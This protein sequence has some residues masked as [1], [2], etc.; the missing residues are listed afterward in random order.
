MHLQIYRHITAALLATLPIIATIVPLISCRPT[1]Y[2]AFSF[3]RSELNTYKEEV[4][5][6]FQ[7]GL[8]KYLEVGYPY[9]EV[10]PISCEPKTRNFNDL[11]DLPTNDVLGNF[12]ATLIDSLT[13]VAVMG[14]KNQFYNLVELVRV[15]F[16]NKFE[17]DATVQVFETTIRILGSLISSHLYATDARK[18]CNLLD[19]G[20][21]GILLDLAK[22]IGERLL[23]VY[24]TESGLPV[25]RIN[26][27]A[28]FER[29]SRLQMNENNLAGM[30]T[31]MLEFG[32]LS[33][34][35]GDRKYME[36]T[37]FTFDRLWK[38]FRARTGL[39]PVSL[40][41]HDFTIYSFA[42]GVGAS[43]D[44]FYEYALKGAILFDDEE[45]MNI[46]EESY[47][48]LNANSKLDW[49]YG[50]V[51][52]MGVN[53][54]LPW[55]D[56]LSAFFPGLQVLA[57]DVDDS[58][59]KH[60]L[61]LKQWDYF[62]G[63]PERWEFE[64]P[65][66][67]IVNR[68]VRGGFRKE[69]KE[70]GSGGGGG[71]VVLPLPW[72]PLRPEF[73][74]STYYLYRATK[75]PFYL[76]IGYRILQDFKYRFKFSCGFAGI[77]NLLTDQRQDRMET[78]VLSETLKYLYL[79]FDEDNEINHSRDNVIFSTEA[80]P[81]WVTPQMR[82]DYEKNGF[83]NDDKYCRNLQK[84]KKSFE[85]IVN[86]FKSRNEIMRQTP[87][88]AAGSIDIWP[89]LENKRICPVKFVWSDNKFGE[90]N[91]I[92]LPYSDILTNYNRLFE[93][94][95]RYSDVL[96]K[97][98]HLINYTSIELESGFY[99]I[100][101]KKNNGDNNANMKNICKPKPTSESFE[102]LFDIDGPYDFFKFENGDV[103]CN[104]LKTRRKWRVEK[105]HVGDYDVFGRIVNSTQF[106]NANRQD[107]TD[108]MCDQYLSRCPSTLYR[109]S[110]IDG[111]SIPEGGRVTIDR[112]QLMA[113]NND[114]ELRNVYAQFGYNTDNQLL[115]HCI[116]FTNVY[117]I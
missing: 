15:T 9:D 14:D 55:I 69:T 79:L 83:F 56:S 95:Y 43:A 28:G 57:G 58:M 117:L 48:S 6:L 26:L 75:D 105:I 92:S 104:S 5:D 18:S 21:D 20:Y 74:E 16:P 47:K 23:P 63:I 84:C 1:S 45:L 13:T 102:I 76:N 54:V 46:W 81:M 4:R 103:H 72:Y 68:D 42:T 30:A 36:V 11:T 107:L 41:P 17:I 10:R 101:A 73:I 35:T 32:M 94:D 50:N 66:V 116:P 7:F 29:Y 89:K 25:S 87:R 24:L 98:P 22:D 53:Q 38:Q 39:L 111:Y 77:E 91:D 40:D 51:N 70:Q 12:T 71:G 78:F 49:F 90:Q 115:L 52:T 44:S 62:G 100:W 108:K 106:V 113:A 31:P 110:V 19:M 60:L 67:N 33:L 96:I 61:F 109:L 99:E 27:K 93:I 34:L 80:H 86:P 88:A 82:H 65:M 2:D 112:S 37:R 8:S 59:M 3:T 85:T 64:K 114:P 97:P